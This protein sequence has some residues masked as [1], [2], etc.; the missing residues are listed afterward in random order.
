LQAIDRATRR[1]SDAALRD[2]AAP[3][4]VRTEQRLIRIALDDLFCIEGA[5]DYRLVH[6]LGRTVRTSETLTMFEQRLPVSRFCRVHRS[7]LVGLGHVEHVER[8]HLVVGERRI[9][10]S[11]GHR[12]RLFARLGV[13]A[14]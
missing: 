14:R 5:G 9:P 10:V 8:D 4:F 2:P 11:A 1:R 13:E 6:A 7:W 3:F 12:D